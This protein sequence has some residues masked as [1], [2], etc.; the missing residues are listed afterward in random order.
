[1]AGVVLAGGG[2][3]RMGRDKATLALGGESLAGHAAARLARVCSEVAL[4][5]AGRG[6]LPEY[7]SLADGPGRGPAAGILGA[8]RLWPGRPLL[9]LACDLPAVPEGLLADLARSID[10]ADADWVVPRWRGGVEPLCALYGPAA[11]A[12]LER[13]VARGLLALHDL[14]LEAD[15]AVRYLEGERLPSTAG[16]RRSSSTSTPP[17]I[18]KGGGEGAM[19]ESRPYTGIDM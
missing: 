19:N 7:P 11:L 18:W 16:P 13:R 1:M 2:S 15:L 6:L 10:A 5:D 17:R 4:A 12:A 14:A 8:A 3:R 9:V